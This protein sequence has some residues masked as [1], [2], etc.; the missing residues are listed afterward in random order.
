MPDGHSPAAV[1]RRTGVMLI[2]SSALNNMSRD[3]LFFIMLHEMGHL[4]LQTSDELAVDKW[5]HQQYLRTGKSLKQSVYAMT[6]QLNFSSPEHYERAQL[7]LQRALS[8][9]QK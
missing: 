5:A 4:V 2:N 3:Q 8:F 1:N 7:Q 6:Q 9:D